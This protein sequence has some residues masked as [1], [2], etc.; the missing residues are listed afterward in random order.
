M[1]S[2]CYCVVSFGLGSSVAEVVRFIQLRR[3]ILCMD[4]TDLSP[5]QFAGFVIPQSVRSGGEKASLPIVECS[6]DSHSEQSSSPVLREGQ[7]VSVL[8]SSLDGMSWEVRD[9]WCWRC[10]SQFAD[11]SPFLPDG[12]G[13][14]AVSGLLVPASDDSSLLLQN[15]SIEKIFSKVCPAEMSA[16]PVE[17]TERV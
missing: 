11:P 17:S 3:I 9:V 4:K 1:G 10:G 15:V 5:E 7:E 8:L 16:A 2:R 13:V 6:C 14:V 12:A